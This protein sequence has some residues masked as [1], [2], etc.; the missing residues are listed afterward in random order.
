MKIIINEDQLK[1]LITNHKRGVDENLLYISENIKKEDPQILDLYINN[2]KKYLKEAHTR[3]ELPQDIQNAIN[4]VERTYGVKIT[5]DNIEKEFEQEGNYYKDNGKIDPNAFESLKKLLNDLYSN[6]PDAPK[7]SNDNCNK[8]QGCVSGYRGYNTQ[9]TTFGGKIQSQG[10]V[11]GRQRASALPGFSQHSTGKTFDILSVDPAWWESYKNIK[12]WV[13]TNVCKYGFKISYPTNGVLRMAEPWHLYFTNEFCKPS[14]T[15]TNAEE[16][17]TNTEESKKNLENF[18]TDYF[19]FLKKD[20]VV[21]DNS[22]KKD[23]KMMQLML[24]INTKNKSMVFNGKIDETTKDIL[25]KFQKDNGLTQTGYFDL[26]TQETMGEKISS[27]TKNTQKTTEDSTVLDK[28]SMTPA[29]SKRGQTYGWRAPIGNLCAKG[30][31]KKRY[32]N[33]HWHAGR[34]YS[35]TRGTPIVL[36]K[37]G[38][39][40]EKGSYCFKIEHND[41]SITKYCHCDDVYFKQGD[42]IPSG[43]IVATLG[44]KGPSTGPHLHFEYYPS[45]DNTRTETKNKTTVQVKDVDP[46]GVDD[47]IFA[48]VKPDSIGKFKNQKGKI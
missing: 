16:T 7:S 42:T 17:K 21:N 6:F 8:Q 47:T 40:I 48:F 20:T 19:N 14:E 4:Q 3:K 27:P 45:G 34:D 39:M 31:N 28:S 9:A 33:W 46:A 12:N 18:I 22:N 2:A 37:G 29:S 38:K 41:G 24:F 15:K 35:G 23:I 13:A 10:G 32:C 11:S 43:S 44:N 1:Y 5:D 26:L 30:V 25:I 36:L